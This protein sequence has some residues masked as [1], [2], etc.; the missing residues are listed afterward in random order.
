MARII[1]THIT[2]HW[3]PAP[4][5]TLIAVAGDTACEQVPD[6]APC[7]LIVLEEGE[8]FADIPTAPIDV[9]AATPPSRPGDESVWV[10]RHLGHAYP[11]AT[12]IDAYR[13]AHMQAKDGNWYEV[14]QVPYMQDILTWEGIWR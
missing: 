11:F 14:I 7:R 10:A 8:T 1:D 3:H 13:W 5:Y 2:G 6:D 4:G 9:E 12:E